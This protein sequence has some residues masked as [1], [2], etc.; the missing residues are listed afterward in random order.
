MDKE[1]AWI[2]NHRSTVREALSD[3]E[4]DWPETVAA[5]RDR[6]LE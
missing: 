3:F 6:F 2:R 5:V 4:D 1:E